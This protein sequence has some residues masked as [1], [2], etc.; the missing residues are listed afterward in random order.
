MFSISKFFVAVSILFTASY[1]SATVPSFP[2]EPG[3]LTAEQCI[4]LEAKLDKYIAYINAWLAKQPK[5]WQKFLKPY[6]DYAIREAQEY[7]D[8]VCP[9]DQGPEGRTFECSVLNSAQTELVLVGLNSSGLLSND[10][11]QIANGLC[12]TEQACTGIISQK[13]FIS[14]AVGTARCAAGSTDPSIVRVSDS[15]IQNLINQVP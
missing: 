10:Q 13:Y 4:Q 7:V 1:A 2:T 15:E 8:K 12:M 6:V 11:S 9:E 14:G 5:R 3:Q